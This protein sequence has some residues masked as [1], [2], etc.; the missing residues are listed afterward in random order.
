VPD[1]FVS[2][3]PPRKA[4]LMQDIGFNTQSNWS[5][6]VITMSAIINTS[7]KV[8]KRTLYESCA[9]HPAA[10]C[11]TTGTSF[12]S[13][14]LHSASCTQKMIA[15][16]SQEK[17]PKTC[18]TFMN[19]PCI[20]NSDAKQ[21]ART[22]HKHPLWFKHMVWGVRRAHPAHLNTIRGRPL[23]TRYIDPSYFT[24]DPFTYSF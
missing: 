13:P 5:S 15:G 6:R 9:T 7:N 4:L 17:R 10:D 8:L 24:R 12:P 1:F 18:I 22:T 23:L 2:P 19:H 3:E 11:V 16:N 20:T 21:P 14:A